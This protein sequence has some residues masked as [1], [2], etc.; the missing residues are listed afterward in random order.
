MPHDIAGTYCRYGVERAVDYAYQTRRKFPDRKIF[1]LGEIIHNPEVNRQ[2]TEMGIVSLEEEDMDVRIP[3]MGED[4][5]VI[6]PAL[7]RKVRADDA[8]LVVWHEMAALP[9]PALLSMPG[10]SLALRAARLRRAARR[11]RRSR[12]SSRAPTRRWRRCGACRKLWCGRPR[13]W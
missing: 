6:V 13:R 12:R 5:V 7:D 2:L 10:R 11:C 1:I 4:D 8:P 9:P 3:E